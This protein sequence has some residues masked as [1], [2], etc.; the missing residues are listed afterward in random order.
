MDR[1]RFGL[2]LLGLCDATSKDLSDPLMDIWWAKFGA[3]READLVAAINLWLDT[4]KWFPS[5]KEFSDL[6]E[7]L[8]TPEER[9]IQ[10]GIRLL[11]SWVA[12]G[13]RPIGIYDPAQL[14]AMKAALGLPPPTARELASLAGEGPVVEYAALPPGPVVARLLGLDVP[15]LASGERR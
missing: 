11:R 5:P 2:Y 1:Q 15:A 3:V 8:M 9:G 13:V 7:S 14:A 10:E 12:R 6:L 4:S